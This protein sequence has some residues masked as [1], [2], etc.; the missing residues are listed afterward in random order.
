MLGATA[1]ASLLAP[2]AIPALA[3][4]DLVRLRTSLP[5]VRVFLFA[6]QYLINDSVEILAA[7]P[8]WVLAGFGTRLRSPA[9]VERHQRLQQWSLDL[10]ERRAEQL[11]GLRIDLSDEDHASLVGENGLRP[12]IVIS[13]HV[14]LFDAA[15]PGLVTHRAG[16]T[17]RGIIMAELLA[18][19][20]FDLLYARLGSVF[21]PRNDGQ[22]ARKAIARMVDGAGRN[23]AYILFPEGRLFRPDALARS[24]ERLSVSDPERAKRLGDLS[25]VLPPRPGGLL[26]L[27]EALPEA[28]VVVVDHR[29]LDGH[30]R[31]ADFI[32]SAP[33]DRP[34]TVA[35]RRIPRS[36]IPS[37][38][39]AQTRWLDDLWLGLDRDLRRT[40]REWP[41]QPRRPVS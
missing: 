31:L 3:V 4:A 9:S 20:G 41:G 12:V 21:I 23:T 16:F 2:V 11:L 32:R 8:Y 5:S 22:S 7:G 34:I 40:G 18:D 36:E 30:Q 38:P 1:L 35:V 28:D 15:L 26:T 39:N 24:I 13:R 10:L 19:P 37:E 17:A 29:G 27:L 25:S 14:S 6:L 33:V